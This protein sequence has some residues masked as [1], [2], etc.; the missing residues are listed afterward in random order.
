[1]ST[2]SE[3]SLEKRLI[4]AGPDAP[5]KEWVAPERQSQEV[6]NA[7]NAYEAEHEEEIEKTDA[8]QVAING[9]INIILDLTNAGFDDKNINYL[10]R[11]EAE[12]LAQEQ[13]ADNAESEAGDRSMDIGSEDSE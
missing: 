13:E 3:P 7:V 11:R 10:F 4:P 1:M 5:T 2:G 6:I 9:F 12:K 8:K